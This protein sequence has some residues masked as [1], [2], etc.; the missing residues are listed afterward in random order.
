MGDGFENKD[1]SIKVK[2]NALLVNGTFHIWDRKEDE[3]GEDPKI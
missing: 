3:I 1:G 2:L